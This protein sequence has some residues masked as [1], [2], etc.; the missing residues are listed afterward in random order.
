[1]NLSPYPNFCKAEKIKSQST[2]SKAFGKSKD[3]VERFLFSLFD[4][5][6][7]SRIVERV[8]KI[9]LFLIAADW[10]SNIIVSNIFCIWFLRIVV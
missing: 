4:T 7:M 6:I 1:M 3:I 9:V 5:S 10:F 8:Y 2:L